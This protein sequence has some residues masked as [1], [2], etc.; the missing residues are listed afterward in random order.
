MKIVNRKPYNYRVSEKVLVRNKKQTNTRSLY[1]I[2][3]LI[4]DICK[5]R[6]AII[7][8]VTVEDFIKSLWNKYYQE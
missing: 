4:T 7:R 8:W 6:T 3:Y 5:N 2:P 1:K